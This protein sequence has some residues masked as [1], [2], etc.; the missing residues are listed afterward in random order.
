MRHPGRRLAKIGLGP[1]FSQPIHKKNRLS[2]SNPAYLKRS[3]NFSEKNLFIF[4]ASCKSCFSVILNGGKD[5]NQ[6]AIRK[7]IKAFVL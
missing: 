2:A 1:A 5:L 6:V 4:R 3:T 7:V